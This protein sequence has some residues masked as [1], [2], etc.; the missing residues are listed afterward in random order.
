MAAAEAGVDEIQLDY[1]RFPT[2]GNISKDY[3]IWNA[4]KNVYGTTWKAQQNGS[5]D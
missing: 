5:E 2:D 3:L 1:I 4:R